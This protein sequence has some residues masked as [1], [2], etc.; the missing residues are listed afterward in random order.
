MRLIDLTGKVF[1]NWIVLYRDMS[2]ESTNVKWIC[3]CKCGTIQSVFGYK[4]KSGEIK[5]CGC[6]FKNPKHGDTRSRFYRIW[7]T[8]KERC[9][10]S[11]RKDYINYGNRGIVVCDRWLKYLN[12]KE[13]MY[14]SYLKH[15]QLYGEDNTSIDRI[16]ND[17]NYEPNNCE[18][19]T[20][21][22]QQ[23]NRRN[24]KLFMA[25]YIEPGPSYGYVEESDNQSVF[26]RKYNLTPQGINHCLYG[27][28]KNHRN[29]EF[30]HIN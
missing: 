16:N 15:V 4:L 28:L 6:L 10:N 1:G 11:N 29:W 7:S 5:H 20:R 23:S 18:W 21:I 9:L 22:K 3:Q 30:K 24:H 25:T 2:V 19:A 26:A 13:D 17:G 8:M 12:F 27:R 14:K